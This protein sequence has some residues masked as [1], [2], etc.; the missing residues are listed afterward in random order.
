MHLQ[1]G[2][3]F[4]VVPRFHSRLP[5]AERLQLNGGVEGEGLRYYPRDDWRN[6]TS[7]ELALLVAQTS[8]PSRQEDTILRPSQIGL[9]AI[10]AH[11]RAAWWTAA[12]KADP[13][14]GH[15]DGYDAF[16]AAL[17][18]FW[19][20]KRVPLPAPCHF[21]VIA[22][23]CEQPATRLD[24]ATGGLAGLSLS[25][26]PATE[27]GAVDRVLGVINLGDEATRVVLLNL[28]PLLM[29]S[30]LTE[31]GQA[32]DTATA[33]IPLPARFFA[34]VPT[35]PLVGVRLDPGDGLW[36]PDCGVVYDGDTR[37]KQDID[38]VLTLRCS[39]P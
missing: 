1:T 9:L 37:G 10:P 27:S 36:L 35:Y 16:V 25:I 12:E 17:V 21:D 8:R 29:G 11:L 7:A 3:T 22:S 30:L 38:I 15:L 13:L 18:E 5:W 23:R 31:Q 32:D 34:A 4:S 28:T 24:A 33:A 39:A 14:E 19:R 6:P 20:F 2:L 26:S